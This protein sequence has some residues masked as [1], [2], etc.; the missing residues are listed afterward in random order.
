LA[1]I[2]DKF[3]QAEEATTRKFGGSGLGL[4]ISKGLVDLMDGTINVK[5]TLGKGSQFQFDVTLGVS[6]VP[7]TPF[8]VSDVSLQGVRVLLADDHSLSGEI[9]KKYFLDWGVVVEEASTLP[10]AWEL[11]SSA[12]ESATPYQFVL[13][14]YRLKNSETSELVARVRSGELKAPPYFLLLSAYGQAVN[15]E[16]ASKN[17]FDGLLLKPFYPDHLKGMMQLILEAARDGEKMPLVTRALVTSMAHTGRRVRKINADMFAGIK[18]L[19][20][21]DMKINLMLITKILEKHGCS[22]T[23]ASDGREALES[24]RKDTFDIIFMDCQM[25]FMDGFE[26]TAAIRHDEENLGQH[27]VIIALTADAMIGDREKCLRA[28]MDDYLNKP[29]RQDQITQMLTKWLSN[30]VVGR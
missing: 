8:L 27:T 11:I 10:R 17:N 22:I 28:G 24:T 2:F 5:S 19:V 16:Y 9:L 18:A 14:E 4:A 15:N 25:P 26:A 30:A 6:T 23:S 12:D 7:F 20:V 13:C 29:I 3:S 1:Y 21:E